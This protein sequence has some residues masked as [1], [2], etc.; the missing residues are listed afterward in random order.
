MT[1]SDDC[2]SCHQETYDMTLADPDQPGPRRLAVAA[3][4]VTDGLPPA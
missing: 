4:D 2:R 3:E 1:S